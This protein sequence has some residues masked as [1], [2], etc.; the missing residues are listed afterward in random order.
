MNQVR[1]GAFPFLPENTVTKVFIH[2]AASTS[3]FLFIYFFLK[4]RKIISLT[5]S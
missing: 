2:L 5:V 3:A 1:E 4:K